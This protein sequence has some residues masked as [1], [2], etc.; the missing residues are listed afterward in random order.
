[1]K[2]IELIDRRG[3]REKHFLREDGT[4]EVETYINNIHYKKDNKFE[5][6]NNSLVKSKDGYYNVANDFK[7][8]FREKSKNFSMRLEKDDYYIE[9]KMPNTSG[10]SLEKKNKQSS[11]KLSNQIVYK[12]I[13]KGVDIKYN[14]TSSKIKE[15]IVLNEKSIDY[16]SLIFDIETN[17]KLL[18]KD[19]SIIAKDKKNIVL[20]FDKPFMIDSKNEINSDVHYKLINNDNNYRLELIFDSDWLNSENTKYPVYIDPTIQCDTT[21]GM[22]DT[23][24]YPGDSANKGGYPYISAGVEKVN[25]VDRVNRGL[26]K[27]TLPLLGT[28]DEIVKAQLDLTQ[29]LASNEDVMPKVT[30]IHRVTADWNE[31]TATWANMNSNFDTN[32][33]AINYSN[34]TVI[35]AGGD[36]PGVSLNECNITNLVKKWYEDEENYG[37]MLK[38]PNE[39]YIDDNFPQFY[40]QE[41][42]FPEEYMPKLLIT[43]RNHNGLEEYLNYKEQIFSLG[44]TYVNTFN[45]NLV[46][47]FK[48]AETVASRYSAVVNLI[49]NT[50]DVI[51]NNTSIFGKGFRLNYD[52]RIN[53]ITSNVIEYYDYDGTVHYLFK[54]ESDT[55]FYDEDGLNL[56]AEKVSNTYKLSDKYNNQKIY[57]L[58]GNVYYLSLLKD[59]ESNEITITRNSLNNITKIVDSSLDEINILYEN[60]KITFSGPTYSTELNFRNGKLVEIESM[61]GTQTISYSNDLISDIIDIT[62]LKTS[63]SYYAKSPRKIY[64]IHNYGLD[65]SL[66]KSFTFSYGHNSTKIVDNLGSTNTLIFNDVGNLISFNIM[67][68]EDDISNAYST[69]QVYGESNN[70]NKIIDSSILS[71]YVKNY[72]TNTSFEIPDTNFIA[73]SEMSKIVSEDFSHSGESSLKLSS[74]SLNQY[75][76]QT[77]TVPKG[78][79]YTFS[80]YFL[81]DMCSIGL[82]YEDENHET[83][84]NFQIIQSNDDF[85]KEDVNIYYDENAT[86]DLKIRINL[87]VPGICYVDDIQLET[88]EVA[89]EYN[90][91]E[92]S[93]FSAG[94][95]DW[96]LQANKYDSGAPVPESQVFQ[97]VNFNNNQNTAL[98]VMM[99]PDNYTSFSKYYKISGEEGDLYR[100]SFWYKNEGIECDDQMTGNNV[101]IY[102]L[103]SQ[104]SEGTCA[105]SSPSFTPNKNIWQ[106]FSYD[107]IAENDYTEIG[108]IFHQGRNANNFYITDLYLYKDSIKTKLNYDSNGNLIN[109]SDMKNRNATFNFDKNNEL[110]KATD[111]RGANFRFE[112]DNI[113]KSRNI[114]SIS[115]L[116]ISNKI[117]YDSYG[118]PIS[119][120]VCKEVSN[121]NQ[122]GLF[123][124]RAKGTNKYVSVLNNAIVLKE[125]SCS[126]TVWNILISN[127]TFKIQYPIVG[128][129]L[130]Y[131]DNNVVLL[132]DDANNI[133]EYI[134]N[135]N[136]SYC[137]KKSNIESYLKANNNLLEFSNDYLNDS[138]FEF[139][140][141]EVGNE[142]IETDATYDLQGKFVTSVTDSLL[143]KTLHN[144]NSTSGLLNSSI[145]ANGVQKTYQYD[146]QNRLSTVSVEDRSTSFNYT[147]NLLS[148]ISQNGLEYIFTYDNFLNL[149]NVSIGNNISLITSVYNQN[150]GKLQSTTYGNNSSILYQY[151]EFNRIKSVTKSGNKVYNYKYDNNGNISK[152]LFGDHMLRWRYDTNK[153]I[154]NYKFDEF[155]T[156]Y[157]YDSNNNITLKSSK[158]DNFNN[159][160]ECTY[161]TDNSMTSIEINGSIVDYSYDSIGRIIE[162]KIL[163]PLFSTKY[164]YTSIGKRTSELIKTIKNGN[165][166]F[167]YKYNNL[168]YITHVYCN[169]VL[170]KE[171]YY[172]CYNELIE[173]IDIPLSQ[174]IQYTYDNNG[175]LLSKK[176]TDTNTQSI[177]S[178]ILYQYSNNNWKDQLTQYNGINISYDNIGNQITYGNNISM[179]WQDG[180]NLATYTDSS[181]NLQVSYDYNCDGIRLQKTVNGITTKYYIN[182]TDI[183]YEKKGNNI[184]YYFYDFTGIA[185]LIYN[186]DVY[187]FVKNSQNDI[188]GILDSN[189]TQVVSYS[190]DSWGKV[191]SVNDSQGQPITD[192]TNIAYINPFRYRGYYYDIETKLYYLNTRYYNPEFGRFISADGIIAFDDVS[193]STNLYTYVSNNPI[194]FSDPMGMFKLKNIFTWIQIKYTQLTNPLYIRNKVKS[195]VKN[196]TRAVVDCF[197]FEV[198]NVGSGFA[199]KHKD[200]GEAEYGKKEVTKVTKSGAVC[201]HVETINV[202][203]FGTTK[204]SKFK[205]CDNGLG[206]YTGETSET[207]DIKGF[208]FD[209]SSKDLKDAIQNTT[210]FVGFSAT[211]QYENI[212]TYIKIGW[213]IPIFKIL[214]SD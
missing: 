193:I 2:K 157:D 91:I 152:I 60:N 188:I 40:S 14:L 115:S 144:V 74:I 151:D 77:V 108:L 21:T 94:L 31:N 177:I 44:S 124:I 214:T 43:Y 106:Y 163:N 29:T 185:G 165:N 89:N 153:R 162:K 128:S 110:I 7:V 199:F 62:G 24:I 197:A 118:N 88:G 75:V 84:S 129:Y 3:Y 117:K 190:Y 200:I 203:G 178:N 126:N 161:N 65:N 90:M 58:S 196:L 105:L 22:A 167:K 107:F 87:D 160:I 120:I 164:E 111:F 127:D 207:I 26:M 210:Y 183:I 68:G 137:I 114:N 33:E 201:S 195:V 159:L 191:L 53:E 28:S 123:K 34:R 205:D 8:F 80:G 1:M 213:D 132:P 104:E 67:D 155:E 52:E 138:E 102:F 121:L 139:F 15:T 83:V 10:Y 136:G 12:N 11:S 134:E 69:S 184:I 36:Y 174:K 146:Q 13:N 47:I 202:L 18:L 45:G 79:F 6:I 56:I 180:R 51:L 158:L 46:G 76:E 101:S 147:N 168:N 81:G 206:I 173:E 17:L 208:S 92:N 172:D 112:Y 181:N 61:Y 98:K 119:T 149:S 38:S 211:Y 25:G 175:N 148:K 122:N 48:L 82:Y 189:G 16:G 5:E 72:L 19:D 135:G 59:S 64:E 73:S 78:R 209:T 154:S 49:Y 70:I 97:V 182:G 50:H 171:Y 212:T 93:D 71:K 113:N 103:E 141:E 54:P 30:E 133:Y 55:K 95:S 66:G 192:L 41:F 100:I 23:Y 186:N 176:V 20:S 166:E 86:S 131:S 198:S 143:N 169:N 170:I 35:G 57:T 142:F 156:N 63:Y 85:C 39:V 99:N 125:D 179:T 145:N 37:I 96:T 109:L 9:L 204:T 42:T 130:G 187:Y 27:F 140:F 32:V 4:F 194:M 116:G 150:T